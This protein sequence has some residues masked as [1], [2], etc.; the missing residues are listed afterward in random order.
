MLEKKKAR[1]KPLEPGSPRHT[2]MA[3]NPALF[4]SDSDT[5]EEPP[6]LTPYSPTPLR[7][8][9]VPPP[10]HLLSD[11]DS[12]DPEIE[13]E[14][15][16]NVPSMKPKVAPTHRKTQSRMR[17]MSVEHNEQ[18]AWD[19]VANNVQNEKRYAKE[20]RK[21]I[22]ADVHNR[23][24]TGGT[25]EPSRD[26][27][28]YNPAGGRLARRD[29]VVKT[30]HVIGNIDYKSH[31]EDTGHLSRMMTSH[32][33]SSQ[34]MKRVLTFSGQKFKDILDGEESHNV[35][36]NAEELLHNRG[37]VTYFHNQIV[38]FDAHDMARF[39]SLL[40]WHGCL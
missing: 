16:H 33:N 12:S 11:S 27:K 21:S 35:D 32:K 1:P 2:K 22:A 37:K 30:S 4:E 25:T 20:Q 9:P 7:P 14:P 23:G 18:F 6:D 17:Q 34:K 40:Y 10:P 3:Q 36:I 13:F 31:P 19:Q 29:S 5:S 26:M 38:W 8:P 39:H 24:S 15:D 28:G